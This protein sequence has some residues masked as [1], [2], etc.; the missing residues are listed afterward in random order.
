M[1]GDSSARREKIDRDKIEI[2]ARGTGT[3][4]GED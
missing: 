1:A 2:R 4:E 3:I